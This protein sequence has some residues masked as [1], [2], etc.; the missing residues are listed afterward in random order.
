MFFWIETSEAAK[1]LLPI[2]MLTAGTDFA[3][4]P[5]RRP[6]GMTLHQIFFVESGSIRVR[7]EGRE[8]LLAEGDA[9]FMQKGCPV[10]YESAE[11]GSRSGWVSF[12]GEGV[13]PLLEYFRATP[14]SHQS[15]APIRELRRA[16]IRGAERKL[17]EA[18]LSALTYELVLAYFRALQG[19]EESAALAAAKAHMEAH[20]AADPSVADVARA[21][22]ISES[23]LYRLFRREGSTPVGYLRSVRLQN[24]KRLLLE[25]PK[26]T[27]AE[28]A[29]LCG[30]DSAAYFCKVFHA[31][32]RTTPKK[33]RDLYLS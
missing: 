13:E 16:C 24:A 23:L 5:V 29:A 18:Q 30:F 1:R 3:Q 14:F 22:G 17:P 31:A 15:D 10:F 20:F 25:S 4:T 7:A 9:A 27:V 19:E 6:N 8:F 11:E 12:A 28:I 2:Y 21:A 32:E 26:K 33:Y